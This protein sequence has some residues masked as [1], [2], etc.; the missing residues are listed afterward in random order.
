MLPI[1]ALGRE[2]AQR[3]RGLLF[4]LD[5]T[6][7]DGGRL[8]LAAHQALEAL[9][10]AGLVLMAVTGRPAGWGAVLSRLW[11]VRG[12]VTE[13]GAVI[14]YRQGRTVRLLDPVDPAERA[15]RRERLQVLA[16][17][18][19]ARFPELGRPQECS[20]RLSDLTLDIGEARDVSDDVV[21]QV[22]ELARARGF[23]TV[24]STVHL[25]LS[26]DDEDK[27]SGALRALGVLCGEDPALARERYGFIGDSDNDAPCFSAFSTTFAVS[28]FRALATVSPR[29][30]T[31]AA[32]GAGFAEAAHVILAR[33]QLP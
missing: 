33:R 18:L 30:V 12:V 21:E 22:M 27:A 28:N 7:L 25:H 2:E 32:R 29:Y 1:E 14:V 8:S 23:H 6:L 17:D 15:A 13:N 3:L 31:R 26:L 9:A 16:S 10:E 5:D 24:R 20:V 4:D 11:P 19:E